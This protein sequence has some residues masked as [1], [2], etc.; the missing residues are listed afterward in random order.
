MNKFVSLYSS[1][2]CYGCNSLREID[3]DTTDFLEI[4][5]IDLMERAGS[6]TFDFLQ[7]HPEGI[8][9]VEVA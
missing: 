8:T 9:R 2:P 5:N 3:Q 6:A 7:N 1:S 4:T